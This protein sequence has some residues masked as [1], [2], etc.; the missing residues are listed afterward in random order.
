MIRRKRKPFHITEAL[1]DVFN[2]CV[3]LMFTIVCFYP[4]YLIIIGSISDNALVGQGRIRYFPQGIHFQ[5]YVNVMK[6]ND[7]FSAFGVS[8]ARTILGTVTMLLCTSFMAY[9]MSR[10]EYWHRTFWYRFLVFSMY[11]GAGMIPVYM[12]MKRLGMLDNFLVYILPTMIAPGSM[13]VIKTYIEGIPGSLEEAAIIDGAGYLKRYIWVIL[14]LIKPILASQAVF[15]AVGQWNS[16]MDTVLYMTKGQYQTV[17]SILYRY[18]N[19]INIL[20]NLVRS[21]AKETVDI[22][23]MLQPQALRYTV[24][25]VTLIPILL[26]YPVLQRYFTAGSFDGAVKG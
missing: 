25:A 5:N 17:Q 2:I 15:S 22:S 4:F 7:L 21:G 26:V 24:T 9:A 1:F 10:K 6:V 11:F 14:P 19:R 3:F 20:A 8:I 16:F 13:V 12:N 23:S 18:L